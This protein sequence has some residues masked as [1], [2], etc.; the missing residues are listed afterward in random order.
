MVPVNLAKALE[1][2]LAKVRAQHEEDL[3]RGLGEVYLP[4]ALARKFPGA[5]R[6]LG[7]QYMFPS[8]R[9]SIDT[10]SGQKRR[11]HT[12]ESVLQGA[13]KK[14]VRAPELRNRRPAIHSGTRLPRI[15]WRTGTTFGRCRSYLDTRM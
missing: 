11:H 9:L 3:L 2:E 12:D 1:R 6:E 14:A 8:S 13:V 4:N 15:S 5:A 7:W 10:R